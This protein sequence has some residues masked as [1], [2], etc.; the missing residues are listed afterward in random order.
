MAKTIRGLALD[1]GAD[2]LD[3]LETFDETAMPRSSPASER[4]SS[5]VAH[6]IAV[7]P[8]AGRHP[9]AGR[10]SMMAM[11]SR[12]PSAVRVELIRTARSGPSAR[13][14]KG[15]ASVRASALA[16]PARRLRDRD[17]RCQRLPRALS[18]ARP[19]GCPA[20]KEGIDA[21]EAG[22]LP[23]WRHHPVDQH[24][25]VVERLDPVDHV[26]DGVDAGVRQRLLRPARSRAEL[27][28]VFLA[29]ERCLRMA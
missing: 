14:R 22:V 20:Q 9:A 25:D 18:H 29:A 6:F 4:S 7:R 24:R 10:A 13:A 17:R 1:D 11:R 23:S 8:W 27:V 28:D 16:W 2:I 26:D 12:R 3:A 19:A 21:A 15:R 5:T